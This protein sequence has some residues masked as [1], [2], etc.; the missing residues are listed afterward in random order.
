[1]GSIRSSEGNVKSALICLADIFIK[2]LK[3]AK[4]RLDKRLIFNIRYCS[5]SSWMVSYGNI[6]F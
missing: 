6:S 5:S 1:M 4:L 3:E 2:I